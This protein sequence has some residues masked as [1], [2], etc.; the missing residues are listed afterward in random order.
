ME[1]DTSILD[2]REMLWKAR[3]YKWL[4][5]FPMV[6]VLCGAF[7][8]LMIT[9]PL[10]E[11]TV[12]VSVDDKAPVSQAL[13]NIVRSDQSEET[14]RERAM[15]VDS[16]IHSRPFLETLV[17]Q[18]G[19]ARDP[20]LLAKAAVA[21][22]ELRGI[23]PAEYAMRMSVFG[24][25]KQIVVA[26]TTETRVSIAALDT[27]PRGAQRLASMIADNLNA[28][29]KASSI[30]R[31]TERGEFSNDQIAVYEE[32][33]H[34][35]EAALRSYQQSV[36]GQKLVS[37]PINESNYDG[38][39]E[40]ISDARAEMDQIR[41]RLQTDLGAWQSSGGTGAGPPVLR[42]SRTA[43]LESRLNE[44][45]TSYGLAATDTKRAAEEEN[46]KL[47]IGGVRQGLFAEYQALAGAQPNLS[48]GAQDAAAGIALDRAE[49]RSLKLK[50]ERLSG[51]AAS[52][53]R[54]MQS[55]PTEQ[56]E[57]ER[58]TSEVQNNRDLLL[59]LQKEATSSRISAAL[60]TSQLGMDFEIL[61]TPQLPLRPSHPDPVRILGIAFL[62]GPLMG[63]GLVIVAERLG[64]ALHSL[65]QA[66]KE[67]GVRV[68]GTIPR[69]EG[70]A[71][72]GG[73][74]QKYWPVLSI[75]LVLFATA[76]FYTLHVTVLKTG[77]TESVQ[78]QPKP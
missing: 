75:A 67:I 18:L 14:R 17:N 2:F 49:L 42:S 58:L 36:I 76:V 54:R 73:Y 70:W 37:N 20:A 65:E 56:L 39:R 55:Q 1:Q 32:R 38:A 10:Y 78:A 71:Q 69:I 59:A 4:A 53:S 31:A 72:P 6:V 35:S 66:E 52:F 30:Q 51:Y 33:L 16:K 41:S 44:L 63:I 3:R 29:N 12:V 45:E 5:L 47:K 13:G 25:G 34:K 60:E 22:K 28:T 19:Y 11:S 64:A 43:E 8:Y 50:E 9:P 15:R 23:T 48:P 46:I 26:P 62:V 27:D 24:L 61:E 40:V 77:A 7:V 21:A 57:S 68:I 74:V